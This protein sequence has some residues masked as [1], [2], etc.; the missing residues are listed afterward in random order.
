MPILCLVTDDDSFRDIDNL[1]KTITSA[2]Q[3]GVNLLIIRTN[4]H[5]L[6]YINHFIYSLKWDL[7]IEIPIAINL[8]DLKKI[9]SDADVLHLPEYSTLNENDYSQIV[10]RSV[11][12]LKSAVEAE[13]RGADYLIAGTVYKTDSHPYKNP[14]G[15]SLIKSITSNVNIP[16]FA[17]GGMKPEN[18]IPVLESGASGI[19]TISSVLSSDDPRKT[20]EKF[21][22]ILTEN[23]NRGT[24]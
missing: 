8:G 19:S 18:I 14:E 20:A 23:Y 10:G 21:H 1:K 3:G 13:S 11:H 5:S 15:V 22:K 24:S 17:I 7:E 6:E 12:S 9:D 2:V 4:L 16:V